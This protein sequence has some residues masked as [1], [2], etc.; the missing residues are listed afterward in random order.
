VGREISPVAVEG[1]CARGQVREGGDLLGA[2]PCSRGGRCGGW[3]GKVGG[4]GKPE[5]DA[6]WEW[7]GGKKKGVGAD[8]SGRAGGGG[9]EGEVRGRGNA[10]GERLG[11]EPIYGNGRVGVKG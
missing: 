1:R 9:G 3:G 2:M 8:D 10:G 4:A 11:L 7:W 5:K 6:E